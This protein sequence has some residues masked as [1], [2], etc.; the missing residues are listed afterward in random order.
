MSSDFIS[1]GTVGELDPHLKRVIAAE[2]QR[3]LEKI[4]LIP[5]ESIAAPAVRELMSSG[6]GNIYAEGYPRPD[7]RLQT[8]AEILDIEMELARYRRFS[9]PRYYK[10]VEYA[11]IVEALTQ[12]RAAKLFTANGVTPE[13][14]Y[15]NVQ[16]LSGS[17]ANSAVY[18]ALMEPGDTLMGLDLIHGGHLTHGSKVSRSGKVYQ[19]VPYTV[20]LETERLDYDA[21]EALAV[22]ARPKVLV[23]GFSA[24]P[25]L[26][27][28]RRFREIA[29]KCGA[30]L[31]ADIAHI[32]GL[33]A[34]GVHPSPIGI[35]DV[36]TTTTHK[37][38]CGPRG[39]M[40][41]THR[42]DIS[43]RV[44]RSVFPGEQGGP[45]LNNM[46]ALALGLKLAGGE[47]FRALQR[48]IVANAS[49]LARN[50]SELGI[51]VVSGGTE[52]HL[53]LLDVKSVSHDGVHLSGDMASR[54]L[55][56]AGFVTNS[57]AIP[58][59][60]GAFSSTG[61]RMGTVWISQLGFD[62][63]EIDLMA[64]AIAGVLKGCIPFSYAGR[65]R[66]ELLRAKVRK[67]ALDAGRAAAAKL[68]GHPRQQPITDTIEVRGPGAHAFLNQVLTSDLTGLEEGQSADSHLYGLETSLP[69]TVLRLDDLK[70]LIRF[71]DDSSAAF[72][73]G[74][75]EDLSDGYVYFEDVYAKIIGPVAIVPYSG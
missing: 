49:R 73:A 10:G 47:R 67:E 30:Y 72:A 16:P 4:I 44:D 63:P 55:D 70:Y 22:E 25:L 51:R 6:F 43:R 18:S 33:V 65:G 64:E 15:V 23:A 32:S 74:W 2:D 29:D 36:V 48:R 34:A 7:S 35:A 45:H 9:D 54:I 17:P 46:V 50:L 69:C 39:A 40:I 5:S 66:R 31:M 21:I 57:N 11:D 38:L 52:N 13:E 26:V 53:L 68:T 24:Y 8:E 62:E 12:R 56:V 41:M 42:A 20:D 19:A 60:R 27:D 1:Q 58:G 59:D 71:P 37:S 61:I 3:Q 14:L 75:L 28:W